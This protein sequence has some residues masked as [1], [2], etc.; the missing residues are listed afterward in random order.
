MDQIWTTEAAVLAGLVAVNLLPPD[1]E[2]G[3][4]LIARIARASRPWRRP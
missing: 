1:P 2:D 4:R 3:L